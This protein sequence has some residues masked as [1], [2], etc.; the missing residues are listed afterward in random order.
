MVIK[1]QTKDKIA[2]RLKQLRKEYDLTQKELSE[3]TGITLRAI[4]NYETGV[5]E[6]NS[7]AMAILEEYFNVS[8]S[9]LRGESNDR[10]INNMLINKYNDEKTYLDAFKLI[11]QGESDK[12]KKLIESIIQSL[13]KILDEFDDDEKSLILQVLSNQLKSLSQK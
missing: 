13:E 3:K 4:R 1:L 10:N 5:R 2:E 9:F 12:N 6:P 8:G 7:K 11:A